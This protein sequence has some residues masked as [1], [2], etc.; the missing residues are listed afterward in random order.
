[1]NE[2]NEQFNRVNQGAQQSDSPPNTTENGTPPPVGEANTPPGGQNPGYRPPNGPGYYGPYPPY[3]APQPPKFRI[4]ADKK[5]L[6]F[7]P[8]AL[9]LCA[10]GVFA[11]LWGT[12]QAGFAAAFLLMFLG[13]SGYL[14]KKGNAPGFY[15]TVCGLLSLALSGVFVI[16]SS[17]PIRFF[18]AIAMTCT[19]IVWF[20][21]LAGKRL[22]AG[23][24][25]MIGYVAAPLGNAIEEMPQS[26][27]AVFSARSGGKRSMPKALLGVL[28]AVPVL[29]A[30]IPLLMRADVAFDGMVSSVFKSFGSVALQLLLSLVLTPF[31]LAFAFSLRKKPAP[32][33]AE[34]KQRKG[35]DTAFTASF[36]GILSLCYLVYLFSQLFYFVSAFA[37]FL[38]TGYHFSFAEYARRGFFEL[39]MIAGINLLV[40]YFMIL[41]ARKN[42]GRIPGVL[43]ALGVFIALFTLFLIA[44]ALAKN[45]MYIENFGMTILRVGSSAFLCALAI[46]FFAA[47]LRCFFRKVRILPVAVVT[48]SAVLCVLGWM[49]LNAVCAKYNYDAYRSGKLKTLDLE[50]MYNLGEE[51]VPYLA[52]T[53]KRRQKKTTPRSSCISRFR[54]SMTGRTCRSQ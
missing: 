43:R 7:A 52:G 30:V 26:V 34:A 29:C 46:V 9:L 13:M 23:E 16:T 3:R 37:G 1:M 53:R 44:T 17:I 25:G 39:C 18:S 49:N 11:G 33:K 5:D 6:L 22:P 10:F 50:Y 38:P 8:A 45:I 14:I 2:N 28:C 12:F 20:S 42:E 27:K 54:S 41:F 40:L 51:G 4:V 15:A 31:V 19:S 48:V 24:L 36:M 35:L 32:P 21:S 47:S